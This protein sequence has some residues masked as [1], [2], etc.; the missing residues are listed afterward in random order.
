MSQSESIAALA[1][2]LAKA[3]SQMGH[4]SKGSV[5]PH[6]KNR[7]ADL[8]NVLDA[9]REPLAA[10][11]LA[12]SQLASAGD[13]GAACTTVLMH[14]SGEWIAS[15]LELPVSKADA[16]GFG[17]ALTYA[18][19][20]SLAAIC[21]I[22][23]DDDDGEGARKAPPVPAKPA[24]LSS[25]IGP[26]QRTREQVEAI[27]AAFNVLGIP[28]DEWAAVAKREAKGLDPRTLDGAAAVLEGLDRM[29]TAAK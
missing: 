18:R 9:V 5:N 25:S 15:T 16:Q 23:Q 19:R 24:V 6:F 2:A 4:A 26:M 28:A 27:E 17:S 7:Y 13:H 20:Y 29:L 8:A 10:N 14:S 1:A 11:G 12:V 3:Q 22:A 21:G